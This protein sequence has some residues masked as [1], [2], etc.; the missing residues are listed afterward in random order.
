MDSI[1]IR[2]VLL[3][4]KLSIS[5]FFRKSEHDKFIIF[6]F[7]TPIHEWFCHFLEK[8][9]QQRMDKI[10]NEFLDPQP[11]RSSTNLQPNSILEMDNE[12]MPFI[13]SEADPNLIR[14]EASSTEP[15]IAS[16]QSVKQEGVTIKRLHSLNIDPPHKVTYI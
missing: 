12:Q 16:I 5:S 3:A 4:L 13:Y 10:S 11:L 6:N 14:I 8:G 7:D 9:G 2:L 1:D 15:S